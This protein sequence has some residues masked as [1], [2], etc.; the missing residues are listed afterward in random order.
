[1]KER[2]IMLVAYK[3]AARALAVKPSTL[4]KWTH[5]KRVPFIR[6][7][8]SVRYNVQEII[9]HFKKQNEI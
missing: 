7:G 9:E 8:R 3:E 6:L 2:M 5:Q 1:M 4:R